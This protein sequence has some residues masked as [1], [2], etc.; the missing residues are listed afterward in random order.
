MSQIARSLVPRCNQG[1]KTPGI[2]NPLPDFA[3]VQQDGQL[4][5]VQSLNSFYSAVHNPGV[6]GLPSVSWIDPNGKVSEHP[7]ALVSTGQAY[8]TTLDQRDHEQ[9][10]LEQRRD[11]PLVG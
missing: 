10:V 3:D 5:N 4:G 7:T 6:C 1:P 11:I 2:W 9:P 8:V